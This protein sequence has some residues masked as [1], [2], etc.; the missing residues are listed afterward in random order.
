MDFR[1]WSTAWLFLKKKK[2]CNSANAAPAS[3]LCF[4][5]EA[6]TFHFRIKRLS[7]CRS[8]LAARRGGSPFQHVS[9]VPGQPG[10]SGGSCAW[11][12]LSSPHSLAMNFA[13]LLIWWRPPHGELLT[14]LSHRLY[15]MTWK[16]TVCFSSW[17]ASQSWL[18]NHP[19]TVAD[20]H[21]S[22]VLRSHETCST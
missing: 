19:F 15:W 20:D 8:P 10:C 17:N 16:G 13:A 3:P 14:T 2:K 6:I 12:C 7:Q 1:T 18:T 9:L 21:K 22:L 11:E 5:P 4:K